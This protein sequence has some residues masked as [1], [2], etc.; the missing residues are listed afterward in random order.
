M[1]LAIWQTKELMATL[2]DNRSALDID[3]AKVEEGPFEVGMTREGVLGSAEETTVRVPEMLM[4][5]SMLTWVIPDGTKVK[6]GQVVAKLDVSQFRFEVD[7]QRLQYQ[8]A[9]GRIGQTQR[10]GQRDV[11]QAAQEVDRNKRSV[12]ILGRSLLTETEQGQAQVG[13]DEW[14]R[15][16]SETDYQKKLRLRAK[17]V[18][19]GTDVDQAERSLRAVGVRP[20][21]LQE[22]GDATRRPA[23]GEDRA[24]LGGH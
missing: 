16:F 7:G 13:Y 15:A 12:E 17:N 2:A 5:Q 6:K 3:T 20:R 9:L 14:T 10:N 4:W 19:P 1:A 22:D 18:V 24:G 21:P 11:D 8:Q 23:P